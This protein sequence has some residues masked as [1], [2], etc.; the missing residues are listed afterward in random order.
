MKIKVVIVEDEVLL[1]DE[2]EY[3]LRDAGYEVVGKFRAGEDAIRFVPTVEVDIILMDVKLKGKL[4]GIQT[5]Q[6]IRD[7]K[8]IPVIFLSNISPQ[9]KSEAITANAAAYLIKPFNA[10]EVDIAFRIALKK[11]AEETADNSSDASELSDDGK[12][13]FT[14]NDRIYARDGDRYIRI[15]PADILY[16]KAKGSYSEIHT[17]GKTFLLSQNLAKLEK[18]IPFQQLERIHKSYIINTEKITS[19]VGNCVFIVEEE[20]PIG[21]SYKDDFLKKFRLI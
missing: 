10:A 21:D 1:A 8:L 20:L 5:A 18:K 16:I 13:V 3:A 15:L 4:N 19:F 9:G 2:M 11:A 12:P 7:H 17:S 6:K 14:I